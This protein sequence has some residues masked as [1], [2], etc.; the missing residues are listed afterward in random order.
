MNLTMHSANS[1]IP[2]WRRVS[3]IMKEKGDAFS[4]Q[5]LAIRININRKTL[6]KMLSGRSKIHMFDLRRLSEAL[7]VPVERI[8]Q[9]DTHPVET[10]LRELL[11]KKTDKERA[12][13]LALKLSSKSVGMTERCIHL[14]YLGCAYYLI[15]DYEKAHETWLE[16]YSYAKAIQQKYG[17]S[18][19]LFQVIHNLVWS[20]IVRREYSNM[21][22]ILEGVETIFQ[23]TPNR[24]G[25]LAFAR[26][27]VA[28]ESNNI[29]VARQ[30]A[31]ESLKYYLMTE[32]ANS[33]GKAEITAAHYAY[34]VKNY[35]ESM[36]LL[37]SAMDHLVPDV[38][39]W[40]IAVKEYAKTLL[41]LGL[42]EETQHII[43]ES[44]HRV[45]SL[46]E[47]KQDLNG[48]LQLLLFLATGDSSYAE[49]VLSN[50]RVNDKIRLLAYK[51]LFKQCIEMDDE[52]T[53]MKYS[54]IVGAL[55]INSSEILDEEDL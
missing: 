27:K 25:T 52:A 19:R 10:E 37:E 33:I 43:S 53:L 23:S 15:Q 28:E 36:I 54:K 31:I 51:S 55:S 1:T 38:D 4:Q 46:I 12:L 45:G 49:N 41:K 7:K 18:D 2:V 17:D 16:A 9:E 6:G 11:K 5:A 20:Y 40:L 3:E 42:F 24:L 30:H 32:D 8:L 22:K 48:K 44:L 34:K 35:Y 21:N 14:N 39:T 47:K 13:D 29:V 26:A 50:S